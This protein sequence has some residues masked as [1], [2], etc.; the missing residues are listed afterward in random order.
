MHDGGDG[1][2]SCGDRLRITIT[3]PCD[4]ENTG[5]YARTL[6]HEM[7]HVNGWPSD[8]PTHGP[9]AKI[10]LA[11]QSPQALALAALQAAPD[12]PTNIVMAQAADH[13]GH[14]HH[15]E[16]ALVAPVD[17][18][19]IDSPVAVDDRKV[20]Q[21]RMTELARVVRNAA[22]PLWKRASGLLTALRAKSSAPWLE[23][24]LD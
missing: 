24:R 21:D 3:N 5:W 6:C 19:D 17:L 20:L 1:F 18:A 15:A 13:A 16:D 14:A 9:L 11:S 22:E 10:K 12:G 7:A 23:A 4:V 8:H 2:V